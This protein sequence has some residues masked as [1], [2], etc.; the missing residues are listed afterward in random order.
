MGPCYIAHFGRIQKQT[1]KFG[2]WLS[3]SEKVPL[4]QSHS[5]D[6]TNPTKGGHKQIL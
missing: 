3:T 5:K 6:P 1:S 2:N 4:M